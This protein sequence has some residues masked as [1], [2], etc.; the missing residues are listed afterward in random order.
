MNKINEELERVDRKE[1][2][3]RNDYKKFIKGD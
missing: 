3:I 1:K 2:A